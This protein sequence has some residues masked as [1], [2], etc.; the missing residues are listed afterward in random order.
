MRRI[1]YA[2]GAAVKTKRSIAIGSMQPVVCLSPDSG[3]TA[4]IPQPLLGANWG[5]AVAHVL[6]ADTL[7]K[8]LVARMRIF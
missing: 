1:E 4:D 8:S 2:P 6:S 7:K 5:R 3:G